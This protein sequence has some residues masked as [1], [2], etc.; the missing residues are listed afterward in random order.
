MVIS[1]YG[2]SEQLLIIFAKI[3]K[4]KILL[5]NYSLHSKVITT[6]TKNF[7]SDISSSKTNIISS[8]AAILNKKD[9][10]I[11]LINLGNSIF[12]KR[13]I[14]TQDENVQE[15]IEFGLKTMCCYCRKLNQIIYPILMEQKGEQNGVLL[16]CGNCHNRF[17]PQIKV[18]INN[19]FLESF[20][21]ISV[22][23]MLQF[24]KNE[25]MVNNKFNIDVIN[26]KKNYT[27]FYWN[28]L[29]YF[30]INGLN[31]DFLLPYVK[32]NK[33]N[34]IPNNN[35]YVNNNSSTQFGEL[36]YDNTNRYNYNTKR[37]MTYNYKPTFHHKNSENNY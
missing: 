16:Q 12:P 8:R 14:Y 20:E 11:E 2:T 7:N 24:I 33:E 19:K 26:F 36:F 34:L 31:F 25:F 27:N 28:A 13:G 22:W 29:F 37:K 15:S 5:N 17:S 30:S 9:N 10:N 3:L 23:D 21:L 4:N 18:N 35:I 1:K 6:L 32:D